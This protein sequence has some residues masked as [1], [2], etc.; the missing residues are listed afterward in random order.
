MPATHNSFNSQEKILQ[1]PEKLNS[2]FNGNKTLIVTEFDLTNRCNNRCPQCIGSNRGGEELTWEEIQRI[3]ADL[4]TLG[5]QGFILS[6]GGE[7]L[8]H[9]DFI[10]T[11]HLI[12][13][14][15]MKAGVN[16]NGLALTEESAAAIA[17]NC[18]YFRISLD[19]GTPEVYKYTHDMGE[20]AFYK[21]LDNMRLMS[22]VKAR[23]ESNISF[24]TGF[25]TNAQT[26]HDMEAFVKVS[27]ECG[28]GAAQFRPFQDDTTQIRE[29]Y[30]E[31]KAKYEDGGFKVLYSRQK[32]EEFANVSERGYSKCR[33][34]FFSTVITANARMYAC[35]HY[36]QNPKYLI[37]DMRA[38]ESLI[39]M[40]NYRKWMVYHDIDV[41]KCPQLCRNDSFNKLLENLDT[42][43]PHKEFM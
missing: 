18:E 5:N 10:R 26:V 41:S 27:K 8:L 14:S 21:V 31:L 17:E 34:L 4:K 32:Y 37:A 2:F 3:V 22:E 13:R 24:V 25:L 36:R 7:P 16:S 40:W 43:V 15:G 30:N 1:Y 19:A 35:I 42:F 33:G 39:D 11:L 29:K 20:E 12:R 38:G 6:G 9:K 28:A 23:L